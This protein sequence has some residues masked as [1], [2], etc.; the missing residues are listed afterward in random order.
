MARSRG[1]RA[2]LEVFEALW[3]SGLKN[4]V[5][6]PTRPSL[7]DGHPQ[8]VGISRCPSRVFLANRGAARYQVRAFSSEP[9]GHGIPLV[10]EKTLRTGIDGSPQ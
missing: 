7:R 9:D 6:T 10:A 5:G 2:R 4:D 1:R 8:G 3:A